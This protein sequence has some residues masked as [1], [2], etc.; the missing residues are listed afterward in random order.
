MILLF[1]SVEKNRIIPITT[2]EPVKAPRVTEKKTGV[3]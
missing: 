2:M 3:S 1:V